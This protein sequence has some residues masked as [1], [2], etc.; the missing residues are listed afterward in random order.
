MA[1][2]KGLVAWENT[3]IRYS[4]MMLISAMP[5]VEIHEKLAT[6]TVQLLASITGLIVVNSRQYRRMNAFIA[7]FTL[8]KFARAQS[9]HMEASTS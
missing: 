8:C 7:A 5:G 9:F 2:D 3:D 6:V 1:A 4:D